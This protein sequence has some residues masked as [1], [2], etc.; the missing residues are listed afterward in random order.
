MIV[1]RKDINNIESNLVLNNSYENKR[2]LTKLKEILKKIS[3]FLKYKII[4][5]LYTLTLYLFNLLKKII[6]LRF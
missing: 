6:L 5:K 3:I 4:F 2:F 1:I